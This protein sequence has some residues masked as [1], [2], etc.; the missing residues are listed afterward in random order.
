M[1]EL[2]S[3]NENEL[4]VRANTDWVFIDTKTNRPATIPE[5]MIRAFLPARDSKD[6]PPRQKFPAARRF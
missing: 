4:A 5:E 3:V 6:A 1:Y 2:Y